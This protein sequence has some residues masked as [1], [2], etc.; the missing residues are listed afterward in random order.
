MSAPYP[1]PAPKPSW[2]PKPKVVAGLL[3]V[4][5]VALVVAFLRLIGVDLPDL[6]GL[7]GLLAGGGIFGAAAYG[8]AE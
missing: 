8:K 5:A 2:Y 1:P 6:D 4:V 7:A 3:T